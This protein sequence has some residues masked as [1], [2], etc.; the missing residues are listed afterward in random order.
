[1]LREAFSILKILL[2]LTNTQPVPMQPHMVQPVPPQKIEQNFSNATKAANKKTGNKKSYVASCPL[3][4][5]MEPSFGKLTFQVE[6]REEDSRY[7][8]RILH[9]PSDS[10][11]LTV[12]RG[13]D[14]KERDETEVYNDLVNAGVPDQDAKAIAG[15]AGKSGKDAKQY[16]KDNKLET[17]CLQPDQQV[18][19]FD[20]TY[21]DIEKDAKRVYTKNNSSDPEMPAW[22]DLNDKTREL[23]TDLRYRG[24]Y[25]KSSNLI[26]KDAIKADDQE[27]LQDV[28]SDEENW[29]QVYKQ[30]PDRFNKRIEFLND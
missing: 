17:F 6:G 3:Q 8:S 11:G 28:M 29:S 18:K 13:Y 16:I 4:K 15:A 21:K 12:G 14:L 25:T 10:S 30:A 27:M 22:D 5:E 19:L 1:M 26:L 2:G 20:I 24:D 7:F 9:V 23:I